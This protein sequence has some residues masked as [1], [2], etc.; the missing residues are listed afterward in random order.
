MD[1]SRKG[2]TSNA[3]LDLAVRVEHRTY[4]LNLQ[5]GTPKQSGTARH[6]SD[7]P[8][9]PARRAG[10]CDAMRRKHHLRYPGALRPSSKPRPIPDCPHG[11]RAAADTLAALLAIMPA[12]AQAQDEPQLEPC[13]AAVPTPTAVEVT[14]VPI[15]VTSTTADYFVLYVTHDV[16]TNTT[17]EIPVSV[18]LGEESTTTLAENVEAL[19]KERYRVE[20]YLIADPADVDGDCIDDIAELAD[21]VG[22]NPVNSAAALDFN[23]GVVAVPDRETFEAL[24][25]AL[26]NG[27]FHGKF[28]LLGKNAARPGCLHLELQDAPVSL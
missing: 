17:V 26:P 8:N 28:V 5:A 3:H 16:D 1:G 20:K 14:A 6:P 7:L 23:D 18:T 4:G 9:G 2:L 13:A 24:F 12:Q 11:G 19:P 21:P 27:E 15:V 25:V 22:M 10:R